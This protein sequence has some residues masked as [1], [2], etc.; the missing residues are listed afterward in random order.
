VVDLSSGARQSWHLRIAAIVLAVLA[1]VAGGV[2][3]APAAAAHGGPYELEVSQD[4]AG[5]LQVFAKYEED[6]HLVA[7]VM[8]V[9]ASAESA[10]GR[11]VGPVAL[12]SSA[13]G[14]GRWVTAEPL[15]DEGEWS[16]TV[17]T[18]TPEEAS[19]TVDMEVVLVEAPVAVEPTEAPTEEPSEPVNEGD[20]AQ[21]QNADGAAGSLMPWIVGGAI[22]LAV[23]GAA[24]V[25]LRRRQ[26]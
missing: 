16:V 23:G 2:L 21:E 1:A 25:A 15:L 26:G 24:F 18:T 19:V 3:Y 20:A 14:Q 22:L 8:D 13:E 9:T 11:T 7:A 12:V 5:G 6:G 17:A 4:G 10:D